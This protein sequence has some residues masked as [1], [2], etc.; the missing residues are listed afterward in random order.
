[1]SE[2]RNSVQ[3]RQGKIV[4]GYAVSAFILLNLDGLTCTLAAVGGG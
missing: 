4:C 3:C 2:T 1:M